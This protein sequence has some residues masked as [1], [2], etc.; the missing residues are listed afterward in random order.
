MLSTIGQS[1]VATIQSSGESYEAQ[2]VLEEV[3]KA[4]QTEGWHF[5]KFFDEPLTIGTA[6]IGCQIPG[7]PAT[8]VNTKVIGGS[9]DADHFLEKDESI[10][11]DGVANTV[12]SITDSNTFVTGTN[13]SGT[14]LRYSQRIAAP[15]NALQI[16]TKLGQ[17]SNLDPIVRGRF[18]YDKYDGTYQF[19]TDLK[20]TVVYQVAFEQGDAG[21][22][23]LPEH[24]RRFITMRAARIFAQ[25]YV[26]DPQLLQFVI[27]EERD[28][29]ISF[30]AV[31]GETA[32]Y[33][34]FD[35]S[36][37]YYTVA[38]NATSNI[39]PISNLYRVVK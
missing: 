3:D 18:I 16:D 8:A 22:A 15:T 39:N 25:R 19:T 20:V 28:A 35:T 32:D 17:Y 24:A 11:I 12:A 1:R 36:L 9:A 13:A 4:V 14:V 37:P 30:L 5:N 6:T 21:E 34:I 23:A 38:R 7:Q 2:K 27:Q 10:K 29:W 31:E 26:G 33:S